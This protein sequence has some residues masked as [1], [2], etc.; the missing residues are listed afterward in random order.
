MVSKLLYIFVNDGQSMWWQSFC[1]HIFFVITLIIGVKM[2]I[3]V[4]SQH[5]SE[6]VDARYVTSYYK[7][8]QSK[9]NNTQRS[10]KK[11]CQS[12]ARCK[13]RYYMKNHG[14]AS[15]QRNMEN[16]AKIISWESQ[17]KIYYSLNSWNRTWKF[18]GKWGRKCAKLL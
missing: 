1:S 11:R 10:S 12:L 17:S 6:Y 9:T 5:L 4:K 8:Q 18:E 16:L 13:F 14:S 2:K 7:S 3:I 15:K